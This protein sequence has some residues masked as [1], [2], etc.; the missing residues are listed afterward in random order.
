MER[1]WYF[2]VS[3]TQIPELNLRGLISL[4]YESAHLKTNHDG[5]RCGMC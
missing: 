1:E 2:L 5:Q 3:L 4:I